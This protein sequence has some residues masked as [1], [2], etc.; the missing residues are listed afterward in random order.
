MGKPWGLSMILHFLNLHRIE[1]FFW[2]C[3]SLQLSRSQIGVPKMENPQDFPTNSYW[4][5]IESEYDIRIGIIIIGLYWIKLILNHMGI[6]IYYNY[7][8]I[9]T[10]AKRREFSG[11]IHFI[12]SNFIIPATPSN[13]SGVHGIMGWRKWSLFFIFQTR[14]SKLGVLTPKSE[15]NVMFEDITKEEEPDYNL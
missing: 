12:T 8:Y 10:G 2:P 7:I 3:L 13:P 5:D 9:L 11:M 14:C 4:H 15:I 6:I 1:K